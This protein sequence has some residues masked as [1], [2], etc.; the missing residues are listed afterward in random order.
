MAGGSDGNIDFFLGNMN[1]PK[2]AFKEVNVANL[3]SMLA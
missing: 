3:N 1:R 2:I